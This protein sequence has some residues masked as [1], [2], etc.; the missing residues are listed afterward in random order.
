MTQTKRTNKTNRTAKKHSTKPAAN[1]MSSAK[2]RAKEVAKKKKMIAIGGA[3]AA[4]IVVA[5]GAV[6]FT[7]SAAVNKVPADTICDNV[8]IETVDVSGMKAEEAKVAVE[9]KIA[10]YQGMSVSLTAEEATVDVTLTELGFGFE[11]VDK[12]VEKAVSYGKEGN[13]FSRYSKMKALEDEKKVFDATYAV[14]EETVGTVID[15]KIPELENGA[16]D[17]TITR[18]NGDFVITDEEKGV[19]IDSTESVKAI[20]E[21]FNKEWN[22]ENGTIELVTKIDEPKVTRADLEQIT[23]KLGTYSTSFGTGGSRGKNIQNAASRIN[24]IVLMPGEVMSASDSMGSRNAE[25]GYYEAGSYE[26]GEVVQ[27]YGGGV[28][29]VS[30]TLYNAVLKAELEVTERYAHS[31]LVDYVKPSMDAAISEGY[32]DLK[33]KNNTDT[34]IYVEGGTYNGTLYFTIYGKETRAS[35]RTVKYESETLS[36]TPASQKFVATSDSI[37][38]LKK[39]SSGHTGMKAQLWKVV[40][41]DGV[42]VSRDKVNTSSYAMS[43]ETWAVGT[44]TDNAGAKSIVTS[45]ISS[46]NKSTIQ[47]A[48]S[49]AKAKIAADKAAAETPSTG[50]TETPTTTPETPSTGTTTPEA[51]STGTTTPEAP[52]TGATTEPSAQSEVT[53]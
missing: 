6:Y 35:N 23:D 49:E 7:L 33:F 3:A 31:M 18:S 36:T 1:N 11:N 15:E 41:E 29:Q 17:A 5:F 44:A 53:E 14:N 26:N 42:E 45:A 12:L 13:V 20:N 22:R 30:T 27:S 32:K 25:N 52:S 48:I 8:Y 39:T 47:K 38:T 28:C 4:I 50:T 10:E 21:Y 37:G 24:G 9:Q 16:K 34:P 19:T 40:Y 43:G 51:P 46:Q 2:R